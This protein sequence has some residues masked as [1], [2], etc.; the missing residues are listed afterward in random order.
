MDEQELAWKEIE[1]SLFTDEERV[2]VGPDRRYRSG[3]CP[4]LARCAVPD[5]LIRPR[6]RCLI[7]SRASGN[8]APPDRQCKL[9]AL[10][11]LPPFCGNKLANARG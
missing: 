1:A 6:R 10:G 5:R 2:R 7:F 3:L 4:R 11:P 8:E 9:G